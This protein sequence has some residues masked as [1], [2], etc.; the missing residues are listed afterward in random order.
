MSKVILFFLLGFL[1]LV[2][3][4]T[5]T[6]SETVAAVKDAAIEDQDG[7]DSVIHSANDMKTEETIVVP[8][9]A[10][11][12]TIVGQSSTRTCSPL[13]TSVLN[14]NQCCSLAASAIDSTNIKKCCL[15]E[16]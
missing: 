14:I 2:A 9:S 15:A 5:E 10:V 6:G 3:A 11:Q 8:N 7:A 16:S 12:E 13:G 4:S 1:S